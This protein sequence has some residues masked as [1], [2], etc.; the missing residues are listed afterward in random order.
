MSDVFTQ[1]QVFINKSD[2]QSNFL[3]N[4]SVVVAGTIK[5]KFKVMKGPKGIFAAFP[6]EKVQKEGSEDIQ[7]YPQMN[8]LDDTT[9][10]LFQTEAIAA[11]NEVLA[12]TVSPPATSKKST[13]NIPF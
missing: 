11:Y 4:G 3:A 1:F 9:K 5:C 2:K 12:G 6:S 7:Y 13:A 8:L 10:E